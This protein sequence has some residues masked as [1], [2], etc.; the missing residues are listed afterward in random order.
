M[1]VDIGGMLDAAAVEMKQTEVFA[2]KGEQTNKS[3]V[4][5]LDEYLPNGKSL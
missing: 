5:L 4:R 3:S 2:G 1:E